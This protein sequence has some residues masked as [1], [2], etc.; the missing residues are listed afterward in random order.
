M[1]T[2]HC[3]QLSELGLSPVCPQHGPPLMP[4]LGPTIHQDRG[5]LP[6]ETQVITMPPSESG[7]L[8][9]S[10]LEHLSLKECKQQLFTLRLK[11]SSGVLSSTSPFFFLCPY[12]VKDTSACFPTNSILK[13]SVLHHQVCLLY[14]AQLLLPKSLSVDRCQLTFP[15]CSTSNPACLL[16]SWWA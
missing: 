5:C 8:G 12:P 7:L 2:A 1:T 10:K 16:G 15:S 6:Y 14:L 9:V 13:G 3:L 4:N 11:S